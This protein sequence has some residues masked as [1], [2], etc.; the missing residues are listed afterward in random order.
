M[1]GGGGFGI[2]V[3]L[4]RAGLLKWVRSMFAV[5]VIKAEVVGERC[6]GERAV[7]KA[8]DSE[9]SNIFLLTEFLH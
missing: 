1:A 9:E 8:E 2:A 3:E 5:A 4:W 7:A 6:E